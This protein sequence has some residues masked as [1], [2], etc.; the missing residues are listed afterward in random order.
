SDGPVVSSARAPHAPGRSSLDQFPI[1]AEAGVR[2]QAA[3]RTDRGVT[4]HLLVPLGPHLLLVFAGSGQAHE[5]GFPRCYLLRPRVV[6]ARSRRLAG[7]R[8]LRTLRL[9]PLAPSAH[10]PG[11]NSAQRKPRSL[12]RSEGSLRVRDAAR[13]PCALLNHEPPRTTRGA[14]A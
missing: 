9:A 4:N 10:D 2:G 11:L 1:S 14:D 5:G 6:G 12:T 7:S 3:Y 8:V 13:T